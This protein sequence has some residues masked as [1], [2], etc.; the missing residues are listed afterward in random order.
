[1]PERVVAPWW[2]GLDQ[3]SFRFPVADEVR[4]KRSTS[5]PAAR[6]TPPPAARYTPPPAARPAVQGTAT[7]R[8]TMTI[9]GRGAERNLP[10]TRPTL[11]RHER[12]S[13][14]PDRMAFW[15]VVL[16]IFLILVAA[17]S[18]HAAIL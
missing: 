8:R 17:A 6:H 18:A 5:P 4:A 14:Q 7:P 1:M 16:G 13:F 11:R 3:E 2:E 10:A 12:A 9:Q 15:A